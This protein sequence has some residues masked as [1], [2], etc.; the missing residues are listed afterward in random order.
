MLLLLL[1]RLQLLWRLLLMFLS[2]AMS[3]RNR[4]SCKGLLLLQ[5]LQNV[6]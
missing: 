2:V 6:C 3:L 4:F 1:N 5:P